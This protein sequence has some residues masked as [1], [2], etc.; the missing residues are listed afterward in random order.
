MSGRRVAPIGDGRLAK[1]FRVQAADPLMRSAYSLTVNVAL[2]AGLGVA[3]WIVAARLYDT[4]TVGRDAALI[5]AMIELSTICQL[6][7]VNALT[8]FLPSLERGTARALLGAYGLSGGVAL[9]VGVGFVVGAPMISDEFGF[10]RESL[11]FAGLY[12][13]AQILWTWFA[14][15]DAALTAMR[16]APWLPVENGVFGVLKL[17]AL[18]L[19][20]ALGAAHGVFL[21]S[22]LPVVL[23]LVPVNLFLFRTAIPEHLRRH[24]PAGSAL[25]RLGR[26]RLVGFL[27]QDYGATV[28][29]QASTTAL[30]LLI[31]ALLGSSAN[32]YFYIPYMMIATFNLLF[33]S[34][35]MS[36]VVE[37]ALAEHRIRALAARMARRF[38]LPI[39]IGAVVM[40]AAA[41]LILLPFGADY[42]REGTPVL[43]ILACGCLFRAVT[44][45]YI[46]ISRLQGKGARILAVEC[47]QM[48]LLLGG[49]ATLANP[50]GLPGVALSWLGATAIVGL[51]SL[52]FL[53][54]FFRVGQQRGAAVAGFATRGESR[55]HL[56][57]ADRNH[58]APREAAGIVPVLLYHSVE[59]RPRRGDRR[60]ALSLADFV[61]HADAIT[62][63]GRVP[64]RIAELAAGLRGERPLPERP[65][66]I[67]F[68]DGF[69]NTYEAAEELLRRNLSLT[70]YVTTGEVGAPNRLSAAQL[71]E[72]VHMHSV[73]VGAHTITHPRLDELDG[74]QLSAEVT[75]S[76]AQLEE[77]T[78]VGV[79]S[80]S[81]PHGAYDQRAREA[82]IAAGYSS[83]V[84]VKNAISHPHDD[85]F[86][87][88]RWTVTWGT[89]ASRIAQVLEG[90]RV[91]QAWSHERLR[92]RAYRTA[93]RRRRVLTQA[94]GVRG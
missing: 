80:F 74:R 91:R 28:L 39:V 44:M 22:A 26:R 86:A 71:G 13:L 16:R 4:E 36:L 59:D 24:R 72:L 46:A 33:F 90:E 19:A 21:A 47:I 49:V 31:V 55:D 56:G 87:I 81:Y 38:G 63:S 23:L 45:L 29:A 64:L 11:L 32:A 77:Q 75:G 41:P 70:V 89:S 94:L 27:A 17:A 78:G 93:R 18:P 6:N 68:D 61:A 92:T 65:V 8:R 60:Y 15:Q 62:A 79:G 84:A 50:L 30:P 40:V 88:A 9:V 54:R 34:V 7:M 48:M 35:S 37:G 58:P 76:K 57:V 12:V 20:L 42:V 52:A 43:R 25:R 69:A 53:V 10:L 14:L 5:A 83:A 66:A 82:V 3:Y 1:R 67:T 73:E 85:P 2:T 51:P